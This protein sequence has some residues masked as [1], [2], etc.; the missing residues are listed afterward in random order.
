[1]AEAVLR[2]A[3]GPEF[4]GGLTLAFLAGTATTLPFLLG[5]AYAGE[6]LEAS[7]VDAARHGRVWRWTL[8]AAVTSIAIN[9]VLM[10]VLPVASALQAFAWLRW[11]ASVGAGVGALVGVTEARAVQNAS[12]AA[13]SEARATHFE[14][15][16]DRLDYLNSLLRHEVLNA[17]NE[18]QGYASLL[19]DEHDPDSPVAEYTDRIDDR[20]DALTSVIDDVSVLLQ[21][22]RQP[23]AVDPVDAAAVVEDECERLSDRYD[24]AWVSVV[25]LET[26]PVATDSLLSRVVRALLENAVEHD[27]EGAET[28]VSVTVDAGDDLVTVRVTDD[29]SGVPDAAVE[30]LFERPSRRTADHPLGLYIAAKLVE[31]YGGEIP[32]VET[33]PSGSTFEVTLPAA[34]A[35]QSIGVQSDERPVAEAGVEASAGDS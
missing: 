11:G 16:R 17:A 24:D 29:G 21:A 19:R 33:G 5:V 30:S 26:A 32:L 31:G 7:G 27:D 12:D 22:S 15:E 20:T 28:T 8:G 13:R 14:R 1:M 18:I 4:D 2:V 35:D 9:V 23:D 3:A 10:T 25:A 6:W 34:D